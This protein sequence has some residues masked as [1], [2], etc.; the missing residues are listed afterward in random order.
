MCVRSDAKAF[1]PDL[2]VWR[3]GIG[4]SSGSGPA[5][6]SKKSPIAS[7]SAEEPSSLVITP[8]TG[9][10]SYVYAIAVDRFRVRH[11]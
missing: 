11:E 2:C 6:L 4:S 10:A 7:T 8:T 1:A 5:S 3:L 9:I